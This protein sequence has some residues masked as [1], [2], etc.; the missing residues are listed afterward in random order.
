VRISGVDAWE[1]LDS[2]GE[3]TV[4]ARVVVDRSQDNGSECVTGSFTVPAGASTGR[5]EAVERRDGGERYGGRG[6]RDAVAAATDDLGPVVLGRD[7]REQAAIDAALVECDGTDDLS[8]CGA[9]AVLAVSGAVAHAAA[10]ACERPLYEHFATLA[11]DLEA[12]SGSVRGASHPVPMP[13]PTINVLSGGEHA[14]GG[15]AIQDVL[16]VPLGFECFTDALEAGWAVRRAARDRVAATGHRPLLADEGGF[17]PP[18]TDAA[19]AF[20]LV[21][22][23]IEDAGYRPGPDVALALDI[24]A[25]HCHSDGVYRIDGETLSTEGM[26]DRVTEWVE[27]WPLV[28]VEDPLVENDWSGWVTLTERVRGN[29][30]VLGDDFLV[31]DQERVERALEQDAAT[32]VLVKPNQAGTITRTIATC[33]TAHRGGLERVISARSGETCDATIADLA[34]G[35]G[36]GQIKIGSLARSER[37]VKYNRL[38]EIDRQDDTSFAGSAP[39]PNR[40]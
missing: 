15:L 28:S 34:V 35:L 12:G 24:A 16:V 2:R 14:A 17:A 38:L 30:L 18:L 8:R 22:G 13:T 29:A 31:T 27:E 23:A 37:L 40:G 39:Y 3:P 5:H 33:Q 20:E 21:T 6:V 10:R 36:A 19:A 11:G 9:N 32:A 26:V 25:T 4:R 1:V 7:P